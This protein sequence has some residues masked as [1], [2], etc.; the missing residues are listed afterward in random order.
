ME[1]RGILS[2]IVA[3]ICCGFG[4]ALEAVSVLSIVQSIYLLLGFHY[5]ISSSSSNS[6]KSSISTQSRPMYS[7]LAD[8]GINSSQVSYQS[9]MADILTSRIL[10]YRLLVASGL[11]VVVMSFGTVFG[12]STAFGYP[13]TTIGEIAVP[14]AY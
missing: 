3:M 4:N 6:F 5:L 11:T 9:P 10:S 12:F 7:H 8:A 2:L 13:T 1:Y 14:K